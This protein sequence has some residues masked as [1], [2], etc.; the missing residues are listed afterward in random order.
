MKV[1]RIISILLAILTVTAC[2]AVAGTSVASGVSVDVAE[3][4][5]QDMLEQSSASNSYGL[6]STV[7]DGAI[8]Q[9]WT[10]SFS[11]IDANLETI[12]AQGFTTVQVSPPNVIKKATTGAKFLQSDNN[13]GWWMFYQPA[14]FELNNE[15]DN[16]LGT[17]A[18]FVAMCEHAHELGV[19]IIVDAV[20]NHMGTKEGDD[21]NTSTDPMSHVTPKAAQYEPEIYNNKLF[22][23]P[24]EKMTY[25]EDPNRYSQYEST[26]DLTRNCTSGLPDLKTED[27]RVQTAIYDYMDELIAAGADGFRFDAAKHI[28]TADDLS[29]LRSDFWKN[30]LQKVQAKY[31]NKEIYAYG[32][33]LNNCGVNRPFSMY[34]K[35]MDVTD[36]ASYWGIKDA[37]TGG[38][39]NAT[40]Y[41]PNTNFTSANTVLWDESHDTYT[42]GATTSLTTTQRGK[43]WALVAGRSGISCVYL[44]RPS[45]N[46]NTNAL[47]NITMGTAN[48]TS[49]ANA[50]T[51][52]INRFHN[53]Y[54]GQSEYCTANQNGTAYIER[55]STGCM[56]VSLGGTTTK[57]VSLT[58]H[59]LTAGTYVDAITGAQF[60]VTSSK[61]TG[62]VGSTGVACIYKDK[63]PPVGPTETQ[64]PTQAPTTA[65]PTNPPTQPP[66]L[67]PE[68]FTYRVGDADLDGKVSIIDATAIQKKLVQLVTFTD[69]Q[70]IAGDTDEDKIISVL[71]ATYIQKF[72]A[73]METGTRVNTEVKIEIT[74]EQPTGVAPTT[75]NPTDPPVPTYAPYTEPQPYTD[76]PESYPTQE[77]CYTVIFSNNKGWGGTIYIY[78]WENDGDSVWPGEAMQYYQVN[79][80][81]EIQLFGF[82]PME[83]SHFIINNGAGEG[84]VQTVDLDIAG[85]TGVYITDM[86]LEGKYE[87]DFFDIG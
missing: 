57:N 20:I 24:W 25:K 15:T 46:T 38:G 36:S 18:Q 16:A 86:N 65:P 32:E 30:T 2:A 22:H 82:V 10:W 13:N 5:Y 4:A 63:V 71:D 45:D 70:M 49:W 56:I 67:A 41:Y 11:N 39:G 23:T 62:K 61:I 9:A 1:K 80:L 3:S 55:G 37:V 64:K 21:T 85:S 6:S 74:P 50:T 44:A 52:A 72:L 59:K 28:E 35:L 78:S 51:Q 84:A 81:G 43:V 19:K 14:G 47:Y 69:K 33:I 60:T 54:I 29:S 68:Y 87:A 42:D 12:A 73:S 75:S 40:P 58:N 66:T 76:P 17:K 27:S 48:K 53:Y 79:D 31:S 83:H 77:G 8:L 7:N 26:Y 34:T